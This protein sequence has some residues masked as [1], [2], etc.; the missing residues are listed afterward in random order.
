MVKHLIIAGHGKQYDGSFDPGA[1]GYI[2][3][4]EHKYVRDDLFP[5]MKRYLPKGADVV[6]YDALKVSSNGNL[7]NIVNYYNPDQVTEI[8]FDAHELGSSARGGH[9]IIHS[10]YLP[11]EY[12]LAL[13]DAIES[14]VGVR[15][16]H[17]G[18]KGISGRNN[19]YNVNDAR[20]R[21]IAYRLIELGF[22][23][24]KTDADIM[25]RNVDAYAK[26]L[27]KALF[28]IV[29]SKP[30]APAKEAASTSTSTSSGS[31]S[32][33]KT[34][35]SIKVEKGDTLWSIAD[36]YGLSVDYLK[37]RNNMK[38]DT[39]NVGQLLYVDY[40]QFKNRG[41]SKDG[42]YVMGKID[43]LGATIHNR[44][45]SSK[46]GFVFK[47]AKLDPLPPGTE[48][49]IYETHEGWGRIRTSRTT[50]KYSNRWIWL[51]RMIPIEIFKD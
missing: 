50:G 48:V 31:Y 6:F 32:A 47:D 42:S 33:E 41:R 11:D 34:P 15:Y 49:H 26:A 43:D 23:T 51:E 1:T 16:S 8:H 36:Q 30:S 38:D 45:G 46:K 7:A 10:D 12:D 27:V 37:Q 28:G 35:N 3:K 19:L 21:G 4:G 14:M 18:H 25:T 2:K 22:G 5:A 9:V 29:G 40:D 17:R 20:N 13:R 44:Y 39:L 24:N